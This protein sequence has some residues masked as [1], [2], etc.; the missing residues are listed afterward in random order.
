MGC[1]AEYDLG[2]APASWDF[3]QFLINAKLQ[4]GKF[5]V[6][7]RDGPDGGFRHDKMPRSTMQRRAIF[8]NVMVPALRLVGAEKVDSPGMSGV[9]YFQIDA[10]NAVNRGRPVPKWEIPADVLEECRQW[11]GDRRPLVITLREANYYPERNSNLDAWMEFASTVDA[12]VIFVRDTA[13]ADELLIWNCGRLETCPRASKDFL[14]RAALMSLARCNFVVANGPALIVEYLD[15]PWLMFNPVRPELDYKPAQRSWWVKQVGIVPGDQFP[16]AKDNQR[17]VWEHDTLEAIQKAWASIKDIHLMPPI[18]TFA[19]WSE[20]ERFENIKANCAWVPIRLPDDEPAHG[21]TAVLACYGPS[22]KETWPAAAATE[23]DLFTVSGA[24]NFM[25]QHGVVPHAQIDCDPRPHKA[26]LIKGHPKVEYWLG[27]CVHPS[28]I[29]RLDGCPVWLWHLHNGPESAD[30]I[31]SIEPDAWLCVGGGSVG[32]R[33]IS[34]LYAQGY[35][36]FEVHGMDCSLADGETHA[37]IHLGKKQ[38]ITRVRCGVRWFD[39]TLQLIDYARQFLD[40]LRLWPGATFRVHGDGLLAH[41]IN[42]R[43]TTP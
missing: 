35:R 34:L 29:K 43:E 38:E 33:S 5:D 31:W 40:D 13:K 12:D 26:A 2:R 11:L 41:M 8:E 24:H 20:A 3:L 16:W 6:S 9:G 23:G 27:S 15:A 30:N 39:S 1:V 25:L 42:H 22:L 36:H 19:A 37:G 17:I 18:K 28:Y 21:R 10:V 32:L 4:F 7:F 14:F